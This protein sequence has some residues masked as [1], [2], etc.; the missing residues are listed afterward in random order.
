MDNN[1][2]IEVIGGLFLIVLGVR[3]LWVVPEITPV[4]PGLNIVGNSA[5]VGTTFILTITNPAMILGFAAFFGSASGLIK[6]P[7]NYWEATVLVAAV[8]IGSFL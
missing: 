1:H 4:Q 5:L 7:E 3:S 8:M 2:W 6:F